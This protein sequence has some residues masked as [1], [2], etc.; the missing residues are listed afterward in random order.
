LHIALLATV[1]L[2]DIGVLRSATIRGRLD[3]RPEAGDR[4]R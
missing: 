3:A 1:Y 2:L 4:F